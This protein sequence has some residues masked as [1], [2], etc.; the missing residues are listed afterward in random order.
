MLPLY[1][2][3]IFFAFTILSDDNMSMS[4]LSGSF[5]MFIICLCL[6]KRSLQTLETE[7]NYTFTQR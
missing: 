6:L 1:L 5:D 3:I 2:N 7:N 4:S